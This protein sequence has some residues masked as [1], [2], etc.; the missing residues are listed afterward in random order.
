MTR[1]EYPSPLPKWGNFAPTEE[2][3]RAAGIAEMRERL[4]RR[5]WANKPQAL[6][7]A[8][9]LDALEAPAQGDLFG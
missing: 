8:A 7:L 5:T 6:K 4:A 3:A 2:A 1:I 9:W